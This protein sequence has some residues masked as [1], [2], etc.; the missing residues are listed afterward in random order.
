VQ[1]HPQNRRAH[2]FLQALLSITQLRHNKKHKKRVLPLRL[3]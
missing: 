3:S 1:E 2:T